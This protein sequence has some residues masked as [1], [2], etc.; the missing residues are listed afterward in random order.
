MLTNDYE[1]SF[2]EKEIYMG[3]LCDLAQIDGLHDKELEY[4]ASQ[5]SLLGIQ[6]ID[7]LDNNEKQIDSDLSILSEVVKKMIIRDMLVLAYI[8][9]KYSDEEKKHIE[10]IALSMNIDIKNVDEINEWLNQYWQLL[11][12]GKTLFSH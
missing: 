3:T 6:I 4:L 8:D 10:E 2:K 9:G 11:E 7:Y 5:A 12:K 1:L